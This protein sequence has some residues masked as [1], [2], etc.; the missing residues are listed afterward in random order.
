LMSFL[1]C[2][3]AKA[4]TFFKG[5]KSTVMNEIT[6][7]L[8][9]NSPTHVGSSCWV[10]LAVIERQD[11]GGFVYGCAAR[12]SQPAGWEDKA[13]FE[14]PGDGRLSAY[15]RAISDESFSRLQTALN[16]GMLNTDSILESAIRVPI[17]ATRII[18]Q[19]SFGQSA[20]PTK[21]YYTLPNMQSL[22][23]TEDGVLQMLVST[24]QEQLNLPFNSGY[25][26][27]LGNFEIFELHP[28]LGAPPPFLVEFAPSQSSDLSGPQRMEI[29][30]LPTFATVAH[31]AHVVGRVN[32]G[33]IIDRLIT[34]PP[35]ERRVLVDIQ[36]RL[37][38]LDFRTPRQCG[39]PSRLESDQREQAQRG[40]RA[41]HI[42]AACRQLRDALH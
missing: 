17:K 24:L 23:G 14:L 20:I 1:T 31:Q 10:W 26:G 25:A 29:C 12:S 36:E 41:G 13:T 9:A 37:D 18:I 8:A 5:R 32:G 3:V 15:Q 39:H 4:W 7:A 27:H 16:T 21:L 38:Q 34:L 19:E 40:G 30:R 28:W 35:G 22:I 42:Q 6:Q 33:V 11:G 2:G